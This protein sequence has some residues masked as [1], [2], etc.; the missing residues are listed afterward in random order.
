M[1]DNQAELERRLEEKIARLRSSVAATN[2]AT[3]D[4]P[5]TFPSFVPQSGARPPLRGSSSSS[6]STDAP[7]ES[8][9]GSLRLQPLRPF[10]PPSTSSTPAQPTESSRS[11]FLRSPTFE[12]SSVQQSSQIRTQSQSFG[13]TNDS[14]RIQRL[15]ASSISTDSFRPTPASRFRPFAPSSSEDSSRRSPS[16]APQPGPGKPLRASQVSPSLSPLRASLV[17]SSLSSRSSV[18]RIQPSVQVLSPRTQETVSVADN[19]KP[20]NVARESFPIRASSVLSSVDKVSLS[21]FQCFESPSEYKVGGHYSILMDQH[22]RK[23]ISDW[24]KQNKTNL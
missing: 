4:S 24:Y 11:S 10:T 15:Q 18:E 9:P 2:A 16:F 8:T 13:S 14:P 6:F 17:P 7:V 20:V 1:R 21:S 19:V 23:L 3:V 5:R 22:L 12:S